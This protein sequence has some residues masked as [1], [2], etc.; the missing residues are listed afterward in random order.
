MYV[1]VHL[2]VHPFAFIGGVLVIYIEF[3]WGE[4]EGCMNWEP[5][6]TETHEDVQV[7]LAHHYTTEMPKVVFEFYITEYIY[8]YIS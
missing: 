2:S 8:I 4:A 1:Y 7:Y 3:C 6:N 5:D